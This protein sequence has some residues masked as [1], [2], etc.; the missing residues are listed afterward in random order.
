[1]LFLDWFDESW[2]PVPQIMVWNPEWQFCDKPSLPTSQGGLF[3]MAEEIRWE[4]THCARMDHGGCALLVGV[5]DNEI[6]Q[7]KGDP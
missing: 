6:V 2:L 5:R 3:E 1:M 7:V 4:K